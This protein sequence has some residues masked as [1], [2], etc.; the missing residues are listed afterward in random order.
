[1][2][3]L[4][5]RWFW[6]DE[7]QGAAREFYC[8]EFVADL[9]M[10]CYLVRFLPDER[11]RKGTQELVHIERIMTERWSIFDGEEALREAMG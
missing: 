4:L 11:I 5:G 1:M 9:G 7:A 10:G 3:S 6:H 2:D 8:G